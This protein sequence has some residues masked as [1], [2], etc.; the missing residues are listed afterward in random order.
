MG[1]LT[2]FEFEEVGISRSPPRT[3][4]ALRSAQSFCY[5]FDLPYNWDESDAEIEGLFEHIQDLN[6]SGR[7]TDGR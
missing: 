1:R 2:S 7:Y 6:K 3:I 4:T 5:A